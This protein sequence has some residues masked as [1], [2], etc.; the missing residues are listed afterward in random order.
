M[1]NYYECKLWVDM[2]KAKD[3]G[4][5]PG[6]AEFDQILGNSQVGSNHYRCWLYYIG[7]YT[8]GF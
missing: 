4:N 3:A 6:R 7:V 8:D 2:I 1:G 5:P